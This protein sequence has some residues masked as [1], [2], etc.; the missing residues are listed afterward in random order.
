VIF[1]FGALQVAHLVLLSLDGDQRT[2]TALAAVALTTGCVL[3]IGFLSWAEHARSVRPS[4]LLNAYLFFTII[5]DAV[6]ARTLWVVTPS[7]RTISI[8]FTASLAVKV[9]LFVLESMEKGQLAID[10]EKKLSPEETGGILNRALFGWLNPLMKAGF[11]KVLSVNDLY[12][13]NEELEATRLQAKFL[14]EW[15]KGEYIQSPSAIE[16]LLINEL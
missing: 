2:S 12:P 1:A 8:V 10:Q 16:G 3:V 5:F 6:R 9:V 15:E 7:N 4:S 13:L 11:G 14:I